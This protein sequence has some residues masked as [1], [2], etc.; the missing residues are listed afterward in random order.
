MNRHVTLG[1]RNKLVVAVVVMSVLVSLV[2]LAVQ[3]SHEATATKLAEFRESTAIQLA[4]RA[5]K[6]KVIA[7]ND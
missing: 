5:V 6:G 2:F 7:V 4:H 1:V 3:A